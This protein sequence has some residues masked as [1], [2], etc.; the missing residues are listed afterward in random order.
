MTNI[1]NEKINSDFENNSSDIKN[2]NGDESQSFYT[3]K[4]FIIPFILIVIAAVFAWKWYQAQ[5]GFVS[6]DDAFID[7]D[8]LTVSSKI[9]GRII[10]LN[11]DEGDTVKAG[12]IFAVLDSTDIYAQKNEAE[13]LLF[14]SRGNIN[15]E[16]VNLAKAQ[17]DFD[18]AES[19]FKS[20]VIS[21]EKYDNAFHSLEQAKAR[22][23]LTKSGLKTAAAR[24]NVIKVQLTNT[25]ISSPLNGVIGKRWVMEGDVV[26]PGQ[27]IYT[28]FDVNNVWVTADLEE[29][30]LASIENGN[31][32]QITVDT[33]PDQKF[34]GKVYLMGSNTASQF[35][36][37]PPANASGNFTKITQRVPIRISIYPVDENGNRVNDKNI[38]L[39]PGMSVEIKIKLKD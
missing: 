27:P 21:K 5:L 34:A 22:Y 32:V 6:T 33:Y 4:R 19:L 8:K 10:S 14:T 9:L 31:M 20:Y 36:L 39:L 38:R 2:K 37:I 16:K 13:A 11:Y 7:A 24:L 23:E 18:R 28:V 1:N 12:D 29:T 30:K 3:K 25:V 35:S 26:Q 17:E 15:L